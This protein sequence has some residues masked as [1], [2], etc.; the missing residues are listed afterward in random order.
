M[1]KYVQTNVPDLVKDTDTG[2][3]LNVNNAKL[4]AYRKQKLA[5]EINKKNT[6]RINR[7]EGDITEIKFLLKQLL[8]K[9]S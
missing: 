9:E 7:I 1:S 5:L 4:A 6:E 8:K 2:A 3:I